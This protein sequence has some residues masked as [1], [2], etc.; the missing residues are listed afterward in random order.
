V[1]VI[2]GE[3]T[4]DPEY[5][6]DPGRSRDPGRRSLGARA[7]ARP[8]IHKACSRRSGTGDLAV[9]P[10]IQNAPRHVWCCAAS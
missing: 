2:V 3:L 8:G 6:A 1:E 9:W 10:P 7:Q 5:P 4:A